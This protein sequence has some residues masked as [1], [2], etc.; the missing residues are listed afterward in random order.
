MLICTFYL[1]VPPILSWVYCLPPCALFE[2]AVSR[3]PG[4]DSVNLTKGHYI[5]KCKDR[6]DMNVNAE[7][8][9]TFP[10][11]AVPHNDPSGQVDSS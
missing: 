7:T 5:R 1:P 10:D 8:F 4:E 9:R 2:G 3:W 6:L 11:K